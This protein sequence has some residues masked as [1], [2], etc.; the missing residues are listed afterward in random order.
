MSKEEKEAE[1]LKSV[2][3]VYDSDLNPIAFMIESAFKVEWVT[4]DHITNPEDFEC[5]L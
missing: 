3:A 1:R 4:E 5:I 2:L